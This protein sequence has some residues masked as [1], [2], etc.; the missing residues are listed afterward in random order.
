MAGEQRPERTVPERSQP[1]E[2]QLQVRVDC[3]AAKRPLS[4]WVD[5]V[6]AIQDE[7]T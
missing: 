7:E 1:A 2:P 4:R 3:Q 6:E 5:L